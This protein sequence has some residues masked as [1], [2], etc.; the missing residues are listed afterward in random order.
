MVGKHDKKYSPNGGEFDAD[1]CHGRK[2]P[3][4]RL[5]NKKQIPN[6]QNK[7]VILNIPLYRLV[8]R[9]PYNSL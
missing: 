9:D 8:N 6:L 4:K 5:T 7:L 3:L 1:E 2:I